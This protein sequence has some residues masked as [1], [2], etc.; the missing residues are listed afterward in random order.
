MKHTSSRRV[1]GVKLS[2]VILIGSAV[3]SVAPRITSTWD[4]V[5]QLN[6]GDS[7]APLDCRAEGTPTP[8]I[9]W[10]REGT[11]QVLDNPI[12]FP[13]TTYT[14]EGTY[15]CVATS[16]DFPPATKNVTIDVKGHPEISGPDVVALSATKG[17]E[18]RMECKA[19]GDP[20]VT[21]FDWFVGHGRAQPVR[22][23]GNPDYK[24]E[25]DLTGSSPMSTLTITN[26]KDT[27]ADEYACWAMNAEGQK[28]MKRFNV[29]ILASAQPRVSTKDAAIAGGVVGALVLMTIVAVVVFFFWKRKQTQDRTETDGDN[30][31]FHELGAESGI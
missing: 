10:R 18:V 16:P 24:L 12:T 1:P 26:L 15:S 13:Y 14:Q 3:F 27:L 8:A 29:E 4:S 25:E 7:L 31:E 6:Y 19:R 30:Y 5:I 9:S 11:S 21:T 2:F 28:D 23:E 20:P 17:G 22:I